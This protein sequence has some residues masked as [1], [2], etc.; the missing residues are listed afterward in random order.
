MKISQ[1]AETQ[2]IKAVGYAARVTEFLPDLYLSFCSSCEKETLG[3]GGVCSECQPD[4]IEDRL[5]E[6]DCDE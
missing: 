4:E 3:F 5:K 6:G 1:P 2:P